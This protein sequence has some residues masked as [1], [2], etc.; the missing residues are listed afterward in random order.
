MNSKKIFTPD[1]ALKILNDVYQM[2]VNK[3]KYHMKK[4]KK[5]LNSD[6]IKSFYEAFYGGFSILLRSP[7]LSD[8]I[9]YDIIAKKNMIDKLYLT[10]ITYE[11]FNML[12]SLKRNAN[13]NASKTNSNLANLAANMTN[14]K[15]PK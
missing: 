15:L 12:K 13:N 11:E 2:I 9:K 6:T 4:N 8:S 10:N 1:E 14:L 3:D 5:P 7:N